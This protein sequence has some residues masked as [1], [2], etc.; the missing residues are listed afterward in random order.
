VPIEG[1]LTVRLDWNGERVTGVDVRSTRPFAATR[2][3]AGK[4][5]V[6]AAAT[7]PK[8]FAVCGGAQ[9]AAA[10]GALVAAGARIHGALRPVCRA[11]QRRVTGRSD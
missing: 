9:G 8:L 4:T 1:E 2:I 10:A 3:L 11:G 7:V 6:V 5:P